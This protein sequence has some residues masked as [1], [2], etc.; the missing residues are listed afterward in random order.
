MLSRV[1]L[2]FEATMTVLLSCAHQDKGGHCCIHKDMDE[3]T[4]Q[5]ASHALAEKAQDM[6]IHHYDMSTTVARYGAHGL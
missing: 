3:T 2:I 5:G 6:V 4:R 1:C